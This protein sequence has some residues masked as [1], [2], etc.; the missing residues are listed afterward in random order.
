LSMVG[1]GTDPA[2]A[3]SL[4]IGVA[5]LGN[6]LIGLV[7]LVFGGGRFVARRTS[8]AATPEM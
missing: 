8:Y 6:A 1:I 3:L 5:T 7:P 2:L 4:L